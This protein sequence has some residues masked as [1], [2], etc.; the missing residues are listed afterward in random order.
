MSDDHDDPSGRQV[1]VDARKEIGRIH[2]VVENVH[3]DGGGDA[4]LREQA[5]VVRRGGDVDVVAGQAG[6]HC[7]VDFSVRL[8]QVK[9]G[10]AAVVGADARDEPDVRPNLEVLSLQWGMPTEDLEVGLLGGL[11]REAGHLSTS[12]IDGARTSTCA[13]G[14]A[15]PRFQQFG[16]F[17][18]YGLIALIIIGSI[19]VAFRE[20][21]PLK[22]IGAFFAATWSA[23][24]LY[25]LSIAIGLLPPGPFSPVYLYLPLYPLSQYSPPPRSESRFRG[26]VATVFGPR[27]GALRDVTG[28]GPEA[29]L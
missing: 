15:C 23:L 12:V 16:L 22:R 2:Q 7:R 4:G 13:W 5:G 17:G 20:Q 25:W 24:S 21:R 26:N 6:R 18:A 14:V 3:E 10:E 27:G 1:V 9:A 19:L 29:P 11:P 8:E 28:L